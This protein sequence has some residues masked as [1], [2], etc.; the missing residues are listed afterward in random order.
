MFLK[1]NSRT[2]TILISVL[3]F[4]LSYI[5][6]EFT[7]KTIIQVLIILC[8]LLYLLFNISTLLDREYLGINFFIVLFGLS[9]TY[10]MFGNEDMIYNIG[11]VWKIISVF[12]FVLPFLV[13]ECIQRAGEVVPVMKTFYICGVSYCGLSIVHAFLTGAKHIGLIGTY[14]VGNKFN[15]SY[16]F[17]FVLIL[18]I[19][20]CTIK[21]F[22]SI[23]AIVHFVIAAAVAAYTECSTALVGLAIIAA[24][25]LFREKTASILKKF[26]VMMLVLVISAS[27]L[28]IFS[29]VIY[30]APIRYIIEEVLHEDMTLSGRMTGF[31]GVFPAI[32]YR[33]IWGSGFQN[34]YVM[35]MIF[36][37]GMADLQNGLADILLSFGI[38][39]VLILLGILYMSLKKAD[40]VQSNAFIMMAYMYIVLSAAEITLNLKFFVVVA[41]IAFAWDK[42]LNIDNFEIIDTDKQC[43]EDDNL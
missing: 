31:E 30:W 35:S 39:G 36:T 1:I 21:E 19:Y 34:N 32:L 42:N 41:L 16:L 15:I 23:G 37:G 25:F 8:L 27:I 40:K 9:M 2:V 12:Q 33:P 13:M 28:L 3:L 18:Y 43:T 4:H 6:V 29:N 7:N 24:L 17:I 14:L 38:V 11:S 26:R 20:L 22:P 10:S 5:K